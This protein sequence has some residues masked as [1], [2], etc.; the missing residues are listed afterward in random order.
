M[1]LIKDLTHAQQGVAEVHNTKDIRASFDADQGALEQIVTGALD[2]MMA[3]DASPDAAAASIGAQ[4]AQLVQ[5]FID[6]NRVTPPSDYS[7]KT[8]KTT[9]YET[10]THIRDRI[11]FKV[12]DS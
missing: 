11:A 9:L 8:Q 3:G 10:G 4:S 6:E 12:V 7:K 1:F 5:N 2:K